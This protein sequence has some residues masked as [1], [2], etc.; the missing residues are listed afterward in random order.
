MVDVRIDLSPRN[1]ADIIAAVRILRPYKKVKFGLICTSKWCKVSGTNLA[2]QLCP[3]YSSRKPRNGYANI[4]RCFCLCHEHKS[5]WSHHPTAAGQQNVSASELWRAIKHILM[6][7]VD[8]ISVISQTMLLF[9]L[10]KDAGGVVFAGLSLVRPL[11]SAISR[12]GFFRK[13]KHTGI[14]PLRSN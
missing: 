4:T 3:K 9:S 8:V 11:L 1:A 2:F 13:G 12:Q 14:Y 6:F 7:F 5:R 10:S